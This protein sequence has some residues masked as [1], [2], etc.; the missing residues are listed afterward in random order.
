MFMDVAQSI[1]V[2]DKSALCT[3]GSAKQSLS[4]GNGLGVQYDGIVKRM[5]LHFSDSQFM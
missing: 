4:Y 3:L 2:A 5:F 1:I